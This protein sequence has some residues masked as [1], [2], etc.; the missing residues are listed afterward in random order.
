MLA[1]SYRLLSNCIDCTAN[2]TLYI[3]S[4]PPMSLVYTSIIHHWQAR[5]WVDVLTHCSCSTFFLNRSLYSSCVCIIYPSL[6]CQSKFGNFFF[7]YYYFLW[8]FLIYWNLFLWFYIFFRVHYRVL[9]ILILI[10]FD[11]LDHL[12]YSL[13]FDIVS[14]VHYL[15]L[16]FLMFKRIFLYTFSLSP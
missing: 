1:S 2:H 5:C 9:S 13:I 14:A 7:I 8:P 16:P 3:V 6:I 10:R 15:V 4:Q 11:S 12:T